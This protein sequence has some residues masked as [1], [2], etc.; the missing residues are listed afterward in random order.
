MTIINSA[1]AFNKS[2]RIGIE[3]M[4]GT[5][6]TSS[7]ASLVQY[8]PNYCIF[9]PEINLQNNSKYNRNKSVDDVYHEFWKKRSEAILSSGIDLCFIMDRTYFSNLAYTYAVGSN[10]EYVIKANQIKRDFSSLNFDLI[11][12]LIASPET[13]L[14]RRQENNDNPLHPWDKIDFLYRL[15]KFYVEEFLKIYKGKYLYIYTD[16]MT[17]D[18]LEKKITTILSSYI[19]LNFF[20][21]TSTIEDK[22]LIK[23]KMLTF[24][25]DNHLGRPYTDVVNVFG[26]PTIY[27]RQHAIQNNENNE[28]VYFDTFRLRQI[29]IKGL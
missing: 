28:I 26:Y 21:T 23:N 7:L 24:A 8:L 18:D 29:L 22:D 12:V 13:G 17:I 16:N 27:Y 3:G 25:R 20:N 15:K 1:I 19:K 4:P 14:Q 9:L 2:V 6:K 11:I 10:E 5:G